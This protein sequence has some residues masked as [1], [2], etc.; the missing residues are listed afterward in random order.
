MAKSSDSL[1]EQ[2]NIQIV[3]RADLQEVY[4]DARVLYFAGVPQRL[5]LQ[6]DLPHLALLCVSDSHVG[7]Q[8]WH[9]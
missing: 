2:S 4:I 1:L 5:A 7:T 6:P 9:G 8:V 3:T